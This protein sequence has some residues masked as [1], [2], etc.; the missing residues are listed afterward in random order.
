MSKARQVENAPGLDWR[1][2]AGGERIPYWYA[3]RKVV[4]VGYP[5]SSVRLDPLWTDEA[6]AAACRKHQL[7]LKH[8]LSGG[9]VV[10]NATAFDGTVGGLIRHYETEPTSKFNV[11]YKADGS[12]GIKFNTKTQY[13]QWNEQI[14][15]AVG[16]RLLC[17]LKQ[18]DLWRWYE[19]FQQPAVEGGKP[20][21][22][23][24]QSCMQQF[25]R[26][27]THGVSFELPECERVLKIIKG[28]GGG[29]F[30]RNA[31]SFKGAGRRKGELTQ[32]NFDQVQ[33]FRVKAHE[34]NHHGLALTTVIQFEA[35]L[36]QGD[37]I[38]QWWPPQAGE[39]FED[40]PLVENGKL[41]RG[42]TWGKH[43]KSDLTM[44]KPTSKSNE[45]DSACFD[46]KLSELVMD[47]LALIPLERRIGP[48]VICDYTG[49]PYTRKSFNRAWRKIA[50]SAGIPDVTQNRDARSGGITEARLAGAVTKETARAAVHDEEMNETYNR[51]TLEMGQNMATL[52]SARRNAR[53]AG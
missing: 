51:E 19:G 45:R 36:R 40:G 49:V 7:E 34:H 43:I 29:K 17:N 5:I 31:M 37:V 10:P 46:L 11:P 24:A 13:Q 3:P 12:G 9:G 42:L 38:G 23:K 28:V 33:A 48:V 44:I 4:K 39:I 27:L 32:L 8:W 50:R 35:L 21:L 6:I 30:S 41:W 14:D 47:E 18:P 1:D 22:A 52:R 53:K 26:M 2:R 20:M 15:K 25:S 16:D